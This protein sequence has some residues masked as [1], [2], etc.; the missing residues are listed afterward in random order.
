[1]PTCSNFRNKERKLG[2]GEVPEPLRAEGR[3]VDLAHRDARLAVCLLRDGRLLVALTRFMNPGSPLSRLP[4][5]PTTPEMAAIMGALGCRRAA[6]LDGGLS[7][8]MALTNAHGQTL[9][10]PGLRPVPLGV[11]AR[12]R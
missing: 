1:M 7:A 9:R 11:T 6:L 4:F 3:G 2:D 5:G 8:Q 10:W 12:A